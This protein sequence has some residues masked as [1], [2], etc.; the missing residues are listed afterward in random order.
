MNLG[1]LQ[2]DEVQEKFASVHGQYPDMFVRLLKKADPLLEFVVYDVRQGKLPAAI[3]ACDAYLI[4]GSRHGV[5]DDLPWIRTLEEFV[6][7]LN[8]AA[9]K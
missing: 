1:L 3:D 5:N 2:C 4:T 7:Q 9:K 6:L 8:T